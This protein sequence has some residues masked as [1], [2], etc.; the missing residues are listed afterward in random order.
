MSSGSTFSLYKVDAVDGKVQIQGFVRRFANIEAEV[1]K[2][3]GKSSELTKV[4][5]RVKIRLLKD[6]EQD[7]KEVVSAFK[8]LKNSEVE[9]FT[10]SNGQ[11][12]PP[13]PVARVGS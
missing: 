13:T 11:S 10:N 6:I 1:G 5:S 7:A 8:A 12:R 2:I 3:K 9:L 4:W